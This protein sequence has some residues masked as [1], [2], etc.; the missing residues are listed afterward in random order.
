MT[1]V[2][3]KTNPNR[4]ARLAGILYL[5]V[6]VL[7]VF[8]MLYVPSRLIAPG[9][10]TT[11]V[12][13]IA[14]SEGLFRLGIVSTLLTQVVNVL[15]VL[16]LY[17]LLKPVNRTFAALMVI[18][19]LL[20]A[21]I[22][23]LNEL[24]QVAVLLFLP[25]TSEVF[26]AGR[27]NALVPL[28]LELREHG[29]TIASIF[30]GLWLLP[31]GYLVYESGF[32]PRFIGVLLIIGGFGYLVDFVTLILFPDLGVTVSQ[33]TFVGELLLPLWL[34]IRGVNIEGWERRALVP[35]RT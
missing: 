34:L 20:G 22:A 33:F 16:V 11:T 31:M 30:W 1:L 26:T 17:R 6:G 14:A 5:L 2:K 12:N 29:I 7:G 24:N 10:V 21:P 19:I 4:T 3:A 15:L 13:N 8:G 18:F 9:D 35:A 23:M 27:V 32:L 25:G 28:F